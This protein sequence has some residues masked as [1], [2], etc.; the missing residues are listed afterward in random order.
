ML[1]VLKI[2]PVLFAVLLNVTAYSQTDIKNSK[3]SDLISR[4]PES[5]IVQYSQKDYERYT[6]AL[7]DLYPNGKSENVEG[8][9][10][11]IDYELVKGKSQIELHKNYENALKKKGFTILFSCYQSECNPKGGQFTSTVYQLYYAKKLDQLAKNGNTYRKNQSTYLVAQKEQ[12]GAKTTIA[13]MSGFASYA[14]VYRIDIVESKKMNT[15][16]ITVNDITSALNE[17]GRIA[18]YNILFDFGKATLLSESSEAIKT[19]ANYLKQHSE[20]SVFIVGHT[21]NIGDFSTNQKLSEERAKKVIEELVTKHGIS[22]NR[23]Q[24]EGVAMLSPVAS[25]STEEGR[26]LNRRVE[27]VKK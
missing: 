1:K 6:I 18:F 23:L 10:T 11:S 22:K 24:A 27:I 12:N 9:L 21:D 19:I 25:N 8:K 5:W 2:Q 16:L 15:D 26:K 3:D 4:F 14:N 7:D 13:V 20:I 17:E